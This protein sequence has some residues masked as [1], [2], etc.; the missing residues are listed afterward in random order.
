MTRLADAATEAFVA[1]AR[2]DLQRQLA[3]SGWVDGMTVDQETD[4][5][6]IS[7]VVVVGAERLELHGRG[8]TLV[9][10]YG[11]LIRTVPTPILNSAF[12]QLVVHRS[13]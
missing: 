6:V 11:E 8:E 5:V 10:A 4:G 9:E 12:R 7:A 3:R 13:R 1:T 2:A